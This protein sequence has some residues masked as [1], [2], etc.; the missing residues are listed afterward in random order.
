MRFKP[1]MKYTI[2]GLCGVVI[3]IN[4]GMWIG[5]PRQV[6]VE[7]PGATQAPSSNPTVATSE[8]A[9]AIADPSKPT[10]EGLQQASASFLQTVFRTPVLNAQ[11]KS[12]PMPTDKP[13]LFSAPWCPFCKETEELL[14]KNHLM[15]RL[16]IVG[17]A[18]NGG[19]PSEGIPARTVTN[20]A[21]AQEA[22]KLDWTH[23]GL[24]YPT[25]GILYAMPGTPIDQAVQ[26]YPTFL[27]PHDGKWYVDIG[28]NPS[29]SFWKAVLG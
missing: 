18:L 28:Y 9:N 27:I 4:V 25:E 17:V 23:Y 7:M 15:N 3:G 1:W 12:V 29:V 14:I 2:T 16:T 26:S 21:Q 13:I 10:W 8:P 19:E 20:A 24:R 22:F 5:A 6:T 11:G